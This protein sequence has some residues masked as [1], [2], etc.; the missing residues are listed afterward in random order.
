MLH[1][2][3]HVTP[4]VFGARG[5]FGG[6]ERYVHSVAKAL[7]TAGSFD[8]TIIGFTDA[9]PMSWKDGT[10]H[11]RLLP[12]QNL[13]P[14]PMD[15]YGQH[16]WEAIDGFD[17]VHVH[18]PFTRCGQVALV[19]AAEKG[20]P[21]VATDLGGGMP[22]ADMHDHPVSLVHRL[23]AISEFSAK[24]FDTAIATPVDIVTGPVDT[25][26]LEP[27][28]AT[29]KSG[30]L[31]VGRIMPHKGI[32]RLVRA[33]PAN[34]QVTIAGTIHDDNYLD[35]LKALAKGKRVEFIHAISNTALRELY[36]RSAIH[37]AP[38]VTL[39][40]RGNFHPNSEL[41]GL[42]TIEALC[43]GTPVAVANTC[44]LPSLIE[45]SV[46]ECFDSVDELEDILERVMSGNW[47][48]NYTPDAVVNFAA[49]YSPAAVGPRIKQ[50][51]E[52]AIES[53]K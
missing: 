21:I 18:Q 37:V 41:M 50:S 15:W 46:G 40:Y 29:A 26:F 11:V 2:I 45:E 20:K 8:Q 31:F 23:I 14:N 53:A 7:N 51:Y 39:D 25:D 49:R 9:T 27:V 42:T 43:S 32:D 52:L 5:V 19:A 48:A 24:L 22:P 17:L 4:M 10:V 36:S 16:I 33:A 12:T 38:S 6:A 1:S 44:S 47:S 28:A 34:L 13:A 3:V 30:A 35:H